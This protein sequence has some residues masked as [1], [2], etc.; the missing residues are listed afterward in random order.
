MITT[1]ACFHGWTLSVRALLKMVVRMSG[2]EAWAHLRRVYPVPL[3]PGAEVDKVV[4]RAVVTSWSVIGLQVHG[5]I[6]VESSS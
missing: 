4:L 5:V 6:G 1:V 2:Q 3:G